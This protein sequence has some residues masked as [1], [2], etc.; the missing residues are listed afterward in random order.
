MKQKISTL[1]LSCIIALLCAES[2]FASDKIIVNISDL[3]CEDIANMEP[4]ELSCVTRATEQINADIPS[5]VIIKNATPYSLE[6][7]NIVTMNLTF[8]PSSANMDF[9]LIAPDKKFYYFKGAD[10]LFR[11]NI[12]VNE[13]GTYYLAIRNNSKNTVSVLGFIYY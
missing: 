8:S 1:I 13:T 11:K 9:G 10:G 2:A 4:R 5:G 12:Q 7:D 3:I 6:A